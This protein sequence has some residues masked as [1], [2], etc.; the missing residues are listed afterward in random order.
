MLCLFGGEYLDFLHESLLM[1][2]ATSV[3]TCGSPCKQNEGWILQEAPFLSQQATSN[4]GKKPKENTKIYKNPFPNIL[5]TWFRVVF[6]QTRKT[7]R[8]PNPPD[9][10]ERHH[11]WVR[12]RRSPEPLGQRAL[13]GALGAHAGV[14]CIPRPGQGVEG[15]G[16]G[17][18][19]FWN[20]I[21]LSAT[22]P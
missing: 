8:F 10:R 9:A 20:G 15:L 17:K 13:G 4:K 1:W 6:W 5:K 7:R 2:D 19:H 16:S 12:L 3:E 18:Y 14:G 11:R 21:G 22:G